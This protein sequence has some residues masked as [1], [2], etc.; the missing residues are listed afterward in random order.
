M[1][2]VLIRFDS[3]SQGSGD[4]VD[5]EVSPTDD[6]DSTFEEGPPSSSATISSSITN[7]E[8]KYGRRYQSHQAEAYYFPNDDREQSRLDMLHHAFLL[9]LDDRLFLAPIGL[10]P[11]RIFD[12][13]AGTGI[14]AID[15]GDQFPSAVVRGYDLSPIQPQMV[16][17]NVQFFV[18]DVEQGWLESAKYDFVHLRNVLWIADWPRLVRQMYENLNPGGW[19]ELQGILNQPYS[20]D[21]TLSSDSPVV[22][23]MDGLRQ[24][25][26][27][28][29]RDVDPASSFKRWAESTGFV[30]VQERRFPLPVGGWPKD[31]KLREIGIFMAESLREGIEGLTAVPFREILGWS[32]EEVHVLNATLRRTIGRRDSHLVFDYVVVTGMK[33]MTGT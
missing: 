3:G 29:G 19:V 17:P 9:A 15:V 6:A 33:P 26:R 12:V 13:G 21:G 18:D 24:A 1:F 28:R 20:T 31:P 7:Y 30:T 4:A 27:K 5:V 23:L 11:G 22:Q 16:P 10:N 32:K 14:W 2:C 25:G 8:W